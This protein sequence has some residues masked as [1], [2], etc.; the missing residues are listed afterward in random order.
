[1]WCFSL[2]FCAN[3]FKHSRDAGDSI[4]DSLALHGMVPVILKVWD[5]EIGR[6]ETGKDELKVTPPVVARPSLER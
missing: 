3:L 5:P 1:M 4:N 6:F 2:G